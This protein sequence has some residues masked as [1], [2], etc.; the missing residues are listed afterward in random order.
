MGRRHAQARW[1]PWDL[2]RAV[3]GETNTIRFAR[4]CPS[5]TELAWLTNHTQELQGTSRDTAAAVVIVVADD[6][7]RPHLAPWSSRD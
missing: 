4:E 7:F 5:Y 1:S 3:M 2:L 6:A